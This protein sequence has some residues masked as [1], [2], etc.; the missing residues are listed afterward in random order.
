[1]SFRKVA[2]PRR[3]GVSD[4]A[5]RNRSRPQRS[6][7]EVVLEFLE[8]RTL[9]SATPEIHPTYIIYHPNNGVGPYQ[10]AAPNGYTPAQIRAA[11]GYDAVSIDGITGDGAGQTIAIVDAYDYPTAHTDLAAF[12]QQFN[13]PA[14][15]SFQILNQQGQSSP[16]PPTDPAGPGDDWEG[17]EALDIEWAHAAAP[18]ANLILVEAD[19]PATLL[20]YAV[21]TAASLPGVSVVSMSFGSPEAAGELSLDSTFTTPAGHIPVTFLAA[22]GD[23]GSPGGYP[24]YSPNVVAVGGTSLTLNPDNSYASE[25]GWSDGGGGTSQYEPQ[26]SYQAGL[27]YPGRSIPDVSIDAD[28]ETGVAVYDTYDNGT[29]TPWVQVGGTSLACP[30]W[31]GIIATVDQERVAVGAGILDGAT[32]TLPMLYS[33]PSTDFHDITTGNNGLPAGP[34]YDQVTGIGSPI[35]PSIVQG[36][37]PQ[38]A[39]TPFSP[40][41]LSLAEEGN[42]V[43]D[44]SGNSVIQVAQFKDLSGNLPPAD[45]IAAVNWGDG[46][47]VTDGSIVD[48]G[49]GYYGVYASHT[50]AEEG[51]YTFTVTVVSPTGESGSANTSIT[52]VDAPLTPIP[53]TIDAVEGARFSGIVGSFDDANP[54]APLTDYTVTINWGDGESSSAN[55]TQPGGTGTTFDVSGVHTYVKYGTYQI[56]IEVDDVGGSTTEI[57]STADVADAAISPVPTTITEVVGAKFNNVVVGSF[58]DADSAAPKSGFSVSVDWAT[59]AFPTPWPTVSRSCT[60]AMSGT[61]WRATCTNTTAP[62]RIRS[63]SP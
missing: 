3:A 63:P 19:S 21:Q 61:C 4:C 17:E 50:Y 60:G 32:Q 12:D 59:A 48:L 6:T 33:L 41:T 43:L 47:A 1:M 23:S 34:G 11:Y 10:T 58:L 26:P 2:A 15:P 40:S 52:V 20:P 51:T 24:A 30:L 25:S 8:D 9:L 54:N 5:R 18:L 28:P 36:M 44:A 27:S 22:T 35:V 53:T 16:L 29:S 45:Y 13:L 49:T 39:V 62:A 31:A 56:S 7:R 57:D 37:L 14:P 55:I 46:T 42:P 38:I